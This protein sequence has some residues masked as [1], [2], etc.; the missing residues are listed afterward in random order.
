VVTHKARNTTHVLLKTYYH[1]YV[2]EASNRID[3]QQSRQATLV[4]FALPF[5]NLIKIIKN[6][7]GMFIKQY[8]AF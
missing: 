2:E 1:T 6:N 8:L 4:P 5:F 3:T 7:S